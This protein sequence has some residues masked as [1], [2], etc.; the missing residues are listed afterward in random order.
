M[1]KNTQDKDI[2][3]VFDRV[4]KLIC[5]R[6]RRIHSKLFQAPES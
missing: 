6:N 3:L 4:S 2:K 1:S 5:S